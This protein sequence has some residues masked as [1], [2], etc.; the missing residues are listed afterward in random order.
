M[1]GIGK[2]PPLRIPQKTQFLFS[3]IAG[4]SAKAFDIKIIYNNRHPLPLSLSLAT[5]LIA[6]FFS[7]SELIST[8]TSR[9]ISLHLALTPSTERILGFAEFE[10]MKQ[11]VTIVNTERGDLID[12]EAMI[13]ALEGG[14]V[15]SVG[16]ECF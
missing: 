13:R 4:S 15:W 7:F 16:L 3:P 12:E 14:K 8:S 2:V 11:G 9:V 6:T 1:G 10:R 5:S